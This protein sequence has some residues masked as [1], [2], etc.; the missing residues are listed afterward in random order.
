MKAALSTIAKFFGK[1]LP[2]MRWQD[3]GYEQAQQ[4]R[5]Y[6]A[7]KYKGRTSNRMIAAY[8]GVLKASWR[9]G[10]MTT[11]QYTRAADV[12][13]IRV[14]E[15]PAGR[16]LGLN[17]LKKLVSAGNDQRDMAIICM[18]YAVGM[19]RFELVGLLAGDYDRAIGQVTI[20]GKGNK[21]RQVVVAKG[22]RKPIED[23]LDAYKPQPSDPLFPSRFQGTDREPL[24]LT[25]LSY[26]VEQRR[27]L[28]NLQPFTTHDMR[29]TFITNLIDSGADLV[30]VKRIAGHSNINTTASYDRR[31]AA[32][33]AAAIGKLEGLGAVK[34]VSNVGRKRGR[35][36]KDF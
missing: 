31:G 6:L 11:E 24:S 36:K 5:S 16:R 23:W 25:G 14:S 9:L 17:E 30:V 12:K 28:A 13:V 15:P 18:L 22:W 34:A 1:G 27:K 21:T 10:Q 3:L 20:R 7:G 4:L 32:E 33:E 35:P 29:R 19:R 2:E 26:V 8:R